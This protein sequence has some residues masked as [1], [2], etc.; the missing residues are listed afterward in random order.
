MPAHALHRRFACRYF[1]K[2]RVGNYKSKLDSKYQK[3]SP[4]S[5]SLFFPDQR[6]G[7]HVLSP[8]FALRRPFARPCN[9]FAFLSPF[10][11]LSLFCPFLSLLSSLSLSLSLSSLS[12]ACLPD[13]DGC[14]YSDG[15]PLPVLSMLAIQVQA[16]DRYGGH[17]VPRVARPRKGG[18]ETWTSF[19]TISEGR[20]GSLPPH[21]RRVLCSTWLP[22]LLDAGWCL[23]S[24]VTTDS[25][26][27]AETAPVESPHYYMQLG[28]RPPNDFISED[29]PDFQPHKN[30]FIIDQKGACFVVAIWAARNHAQSDLVDCIFG[31]RPRG[32]VEGGSPEKVGV[33]DRLSPAYEGRLGQRPRPRQRVPPHGQIDVLPLP[34]SLWESFSHFPHFPHS[35]GWLILG[36]PCALSLA[37]LARLCWVIDPYPALPGNRGINCR[38]GAKYDHFFDII[39]ATPR[40]PLLL[41]ELFCILYTRAVSALH[42]PVW[43]PR[44]AVLFR[45]LIMARCTP[46]VFLFCVFRS[47]I[48]EAHYDGGRNFIAMIRGAKR[49][50]RQLRHYFRPSST[51]FQTSTLF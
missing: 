36:L 6:F 34:F 26:L 14:V 17:D 4:T 11:S 43:Y 28:S 20:P 25:R 9:M 22:C 5:P 10:L 31:G 15:M 45:M 41:F 35:P 38:F 40:C 24:D 50:V 23:R 13:A 39:S 8:R 47:I 37:R 44:L 1:N 51:R 46:P 27:Q 7:V 29:L 33:G 18:T 16:P 2:K 21:T 49:Y 30:F 42:A 32:C 12:C 48:A 19:W 3:K